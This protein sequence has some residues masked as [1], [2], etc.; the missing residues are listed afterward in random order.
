MKET[1]PHLQ[2][3]HTFDDADADDNFLPFDDPNDADD[4]DDTDDADDELPEESCLWT[5]LI[6]SELA[7]VA[8]MARIVAIVEDFIVCITCVWLEPIAFG[9]DR[10][11][12]DC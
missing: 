11:Q 9:C 6:S 5:S 10:S 7:Y 3:I 12:F 8:T 2:M 1:Y 4:A